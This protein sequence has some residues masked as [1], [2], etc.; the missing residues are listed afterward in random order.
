VVLTTLPLTTSFQTVPTPVSVTVPS[1]ATSASVFIA[2]EGDISYNAPIQAQ[3]L[4]QLQLV[5]DGAAVRVTR[6]SMMNFALT[7]MPTE[8][9]LSAVQA[10]SPG[11]HDIH[12]E[13]KANLTSS[14]TISVNPSPTAPG[15]ISVVLVMK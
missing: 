3:G 13:A 15:A 2:A 4:A 9:R 8:W 14:G 1:T 10:L 12:V 5:V 6:V 7:S 11:T